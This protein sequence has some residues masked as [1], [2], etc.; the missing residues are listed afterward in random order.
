M[1]TNHEFDRQLADWLH[2]TSANRVPDHVVDVLLVTRATQQRPWWS[3]LERWLPMDVPMRAVAVGWPRLGRLVLVAAI[4]LAL[5]AAA[6]LFAGSQRRL[7]P[8]FGLAR[9]GEFTFASIGDIYTV[10]TSAGAT[11]RLLVGGTTSDSDPFFW[12]DGT[13]VGFLRDTHATGLG[14]ALMVADA[15]G[16]NVRQIVD[17]GDP[18]PPSD[19]SPDGSTIALPRTTSGVTGVYVS[20]VNPAD[21]PRP[22]VVGTGQIHWLAWRPPTGRELVW[23]ESDGGRFVIRGAAADGSRPRVIRDLGVLDDSVVSNLD[24]SLTPDGRAMVYAVADGGRFQNHLLDLDTGSDRA[25]SLGPIGG[26]ELHGMVSP[27]G[28]KLLFHYADGYT[29]GIQ[30]MLAPIDGSSPAIPIGPFSPNVNGNAGLNHA[31]SPDG[32]SI[33]IFLGNDRELHIVDSATGGPGRTVDW[34][35]EN[36]PGWQRLAP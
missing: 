25:L 34:D 15:D 7:P 31:F 29:N 24:P 8:P 2:E 5:A 21:Q 19:I 10:D 3:S 18:L 13:H 27:D 35:P 28:T 20:G 33:L 22:V 4:V 26:H 9:N 12:R 32:R 11:P 1:T 14:V 6:I 30:E 23:V 16:A 17:F 36:L